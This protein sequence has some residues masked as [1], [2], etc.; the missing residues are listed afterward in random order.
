MLCSLE[1]IAGNH[2]HGHTCLTTAGSSESIPHDSAIIDRQRPSCTD[3]AAGGMCTR[4]RKPGERR[5]IVRSWEED[6]QG[7]STSDR[8]QTWNGRLPGTE[9]TVH[10]CALILMKAW[11]RVRESP[12]TGHGD[13]PA[14]G[15]IAR[16]RRPA[17]N[18]AWVVKRSKVGVASRLETVRS[19][20][21]A[22]NIPQWE[23]CPGGEIHAYA[24][25]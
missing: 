19:R 23:Q 14:G 24:Y 8:R 20:H 17:S 12:G 13:R 10:D 11:S 5:G 22:A 2:V 15:T 9:T 4:A 3:S 18:G 1:R 25:T 16:W 7:G 21:S 6:A